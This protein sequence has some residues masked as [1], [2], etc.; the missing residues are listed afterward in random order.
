MSLTCLTYTESLLTKNDPCK[1]ENIYKC[2]LNTN[3]TDTEHIIDSPILNNNIVDVKPI[4]QTITNHTPY[5]IFNNM[6]IN[7]SAIVPTHTPTDTINNIASTNTN[8]SDSLSKQTKLE[9]IINKIINYLNDFVS[10]ILNF[11]DNEDD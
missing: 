11:I 1:S 3:I 7:E 10:L 5:T 4:F 8:N 2:S 6:I 9:K